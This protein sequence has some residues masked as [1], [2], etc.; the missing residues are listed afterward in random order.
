LLTVVALVDLLAGGQRVGA[1]ARR[2][3][4]R[5]AASASPLARSRK[6]VVPVV[7]RAVVAEHGE[8]LVSLL[9][10]VTTTL[11]TRAMTQLNGGVVLDGR[12]LPRVAAAWVERHDLSPGP[13]TCRHRSGLLVT[14]DG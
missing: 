9:D 5:A 1:R 7:R 10:V 8:A 2:V 6:N 14:R 4:R 11:T 12:P 13:V 3:A